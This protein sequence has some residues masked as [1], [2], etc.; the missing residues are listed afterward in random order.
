MI[1]TVS[2]F[3]FKS[4][5]SVATL[6]LIPESRCRYSVRCFDLRTS[7]QHT[8]LAIVLLQRRELTHRCLSTSEYWWDDFI[9][10][11]ESDLFATEPFGI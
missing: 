6:G 4:R 10:L 2:R 11:G 3:D 8:V 1:F 5:V 9:T 7:R